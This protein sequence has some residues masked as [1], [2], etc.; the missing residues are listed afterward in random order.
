MRDLPP[1]GQGAV[2]VVKLAKC[3]GEAVLK[4]FSPHCTTRA[5]RE[6]EQL[7]QIA[8]PYV[9]KLIDY[10]T[11]NVRG[12]DCL[13]TL[14]PFIAGLDLRSAVD[15]R[16]RLP[17]AE[18]RGIL[19]GIAQALSEFWARRIVH[20]DIKPDNILL[21]PDGSPCVIDLGIARHLDLTT[22]TPTGFSIGTPGYMSPEQSQGRKA[23]TVKSDVF[24][25]GV[26]AYECLCGTHPFQR[27]QTLI[28]KRVRAARADT[29]VP[30]SGTLASTLEDMLQFDA[31][32]R[33]MPRDLISR[34]GGP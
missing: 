1:G 8:V 32:R 28:A 10:G 14:T 22:V 3:N 24:A 19:S 4:V 13:Y 30:C 20:R 18:V 5:E 31:V 11:V 12:T 33:P 6:V 2:F 26:T 16:R 23:L 17:E 29:L 27:N 21:R 9:I 15:S 7:K 34:L 25:L